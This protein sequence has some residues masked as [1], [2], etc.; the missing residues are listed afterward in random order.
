MHV[1]AFRALLDNYEADTR[2]P[3]VVTSDEEREN[4]YF[5]DV[6]METPVMQTAHEFLVSRGKAPAD[7]VEFKQLL[8]SV[9]F[10]LYKRLRGDRF[11]H[12]QFY[13]QTSAATAT[14]DFC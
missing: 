5:L 13:C 14:F 10:K 12:Q 11:V 3:E 6:V 7:V 2:Q 1:V 8:Y 4:C 9:W